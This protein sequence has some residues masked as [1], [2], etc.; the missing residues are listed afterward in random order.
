MN[1]ISGEGWALIIT[2]FGGL[3]ASVT[4]SI[5][6]VIVAL[7]THTKVQEVEKNTNSLAE[8]AEEAQHKLG[9]LEGN[10]DGRLEQTAERKAEEHN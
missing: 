1:S 3:I 10:R 2:A 6:S 4:A 5:I 8:R 7:K 9:T